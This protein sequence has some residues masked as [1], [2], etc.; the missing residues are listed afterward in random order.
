MVCPLHHTAPGLRVGEPW[1]PGGKQVLFPKG[2]RGWPRH[3]S[4]SGGGDEVLAPARV[5]GVMLERKDT[6]ELLSPAAHFTDEKTEP[7]I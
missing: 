5:P 7:R 6:E 2:M 4:G 1:S 3:S